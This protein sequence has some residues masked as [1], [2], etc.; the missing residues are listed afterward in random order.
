MCCVSDDLDQNNHKNMVRNVWLVNSGYCS[1]QASNVSQILVGFSTHVLKW[2][3][4]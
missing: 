2:D 3:N 4:S 1:G